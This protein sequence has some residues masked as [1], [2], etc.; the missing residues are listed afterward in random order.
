MYSVNRMIL[1]ILQVSKNLILI[2]LIFNVIFVVFEG[3][4]IFNNVVVGELTTRGFINEID[5]N[6]VVTLSKPQTISG[7]MSFASL[8]VTIR[9]QVFHTENSIPLNFNF[10]YTFSQLDGEIIGLHSP[11]LSKPT[12]FDSN[13]ITS[14]INFKSL[15]VTG[16]I[17]IENNFNGT[18]LEALLSDVVYKNEQSVEINSVK[19]FRHGLTVMQDLR[20][21]SAAINSVDV[22]K[23]IH[24]DT[25]GILDVRELNGSVTFEN[26]LITGLYNGVDIIKLDQE[27]VKLSGEQFI[28]SEIIFDEDLQTDELDI[29][30]VLND[31]PIEQYL[32]SN[33]K[34]SMDAL[35]IDSL[36]VENLIVQNDLIAHEENFNL[37][38]FD[39]T[40]FSLTK[41]QVI[42]VPFVVKASRIPNLKMNFINTYDAKDVF[43]LDVYTRKIMELLMDGKLVIKELVVHDTL[44]INEVNGKL[45]KDIMKLYF[46]TKEGDQGVEINFQ[47]SNIHFKHIS[48]M[49][50]FIFKLG[51]A[52]W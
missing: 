48:I 6:D 2:F 13:N 23:L 52:F 9:L 14:D 49:I 12:L 30:K 3:E 10:F 29:K 26:L 44:Q 27:S 11:P 32:Y 36:T 5:I 1:L 50:K 20:L 25:E 19:T 41:E 43:D 28:S 42:D 45:M 38:Q 46:S 47:V 17:I 37:K 22:N 7:K 34:M 21:A 40:R 8:D 33:G 39:E 31:I 4:K 16:N 18:N 51:C 24:K 35:N 15:E